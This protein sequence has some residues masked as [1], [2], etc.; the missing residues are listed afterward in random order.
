MCSDA[1]YVTSDET[2]QM[3]SDIETASDA[4]CRMCYGRG[5]IGITTQ[6]VPMV[7]KCVW[8]RVR[9]AKCKT[10]AEY[11]QKTQSPPKG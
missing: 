7:C 11:I 2:K 8:K 6:N 9:Q 10:L 1:T 4:N 5:Y 3:F